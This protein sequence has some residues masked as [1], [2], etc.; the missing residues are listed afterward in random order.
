MEDSKVY[1]LNKAGHD[2]SGAQ[3]WGE[4]VAVVSGN[5]NVFRPDRSLFTIKEKLEK[6]DPEKDY[7]LLSGNTF[8]NVLSVMYIM[9]LLK[10]NIKRV[11]L[12]IYDAKNVEYLLHVLDLSNG[13]QFVR[14]SYGKRGVI[15]ATD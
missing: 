14:V 5:M 6:F 15:G 12:L 10:D 13:L 11:N 8:G 7:L 2:Y 3:Q 4:L 1:I 9:H